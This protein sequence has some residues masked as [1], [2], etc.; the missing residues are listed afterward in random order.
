MQLTKIALAA[1]T[2]A[3]A[4][5][6][7]AA[8]NANRIAL[9][10]GASAI[11]G[12]L[13]LAMRN[14]CTAAAGGVPT[15]FALGNFTT[16]VCANSAVTSG[17][18]G[19][20]ASKPNGQFINFQGTSYAELR[21]NV[22]DGSFGSVRILNGIPYTFR[23][24][25]TLSQIAA[26]A[27][28]VIVGGFSD[29]EPRRNPDTVI[30]PLT[31]PV[32]SPVGVA[33]TFGLAVSSA[34]YAKLF[35]AQKTAGLLPAVCLVT[36][37]AFSYCVPSIGKA[38]MATIMGSND[39]SAAY[40]RGLAFLTNDL[41]DEGVELR[42]VRRVSTSGT[43]AAAQNYFLGLTC[44]RAALPVVEEPTTVDLAGGVIANELKN[45]IRV[46]AAPGT[47]DVRTELMKAGVFA[48]GVMSGENNQSQSWRWVRV[49]GAPMTEN[50]A[51]GSAGNTNSASMKNG[52]YD[53]Y[54]E[55]V[56]VGG[57]PA[58]N[59]FLATVSGAL[60]TLAAPVGLV[61]RTDLAAGF[62]K[63]GLTCLPSSSN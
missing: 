54:F 38:Q 5:A 53:F 44:S 15:T 8:P 2:L 1:A 23:D 47:G 10:A 51:P 49:N 22:A 43:Q 45:A 3:F 19:T 31:V 7:A 60:N 13:T 32:A 42:Y 50:A 55:T 9:S 39:A 40:T 34:L 24:P 26:P 59:A 41:A 16:V 12:N 37:T 14:L 52:T 63:G 4:G 27:G 28:S 30:I 57:N 17:A 58:N 25:V 21:V 36:D 62:N 20:Y 29:V 18:G 6:A 61:N 11:Q 48:V 46:Y 56:Y 35:N 33:Q